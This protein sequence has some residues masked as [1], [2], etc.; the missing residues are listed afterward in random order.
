MV[1]PKIL[2]VQ[3][4][5]AGVFPATRIATPQGWRAAAFLRPGHA[6][7]TVGAGALPLVAVEP[8]PP[9]LWVQTLQAGACGNRAALRLPPGQAILLETDAAIPLA[10]EPF[11]LIPAQALEGWRGIDAAPNAAAPVLLRLARPELIYAGPGLILSMPGPGTIAAATLP[12][13]QARSLV[14]RLVAEDL[15]AELGQAALRGVDGG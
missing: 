12:L 6:V 1:V 2:G 4:L 8:Q 7:L 15:G 13:H 11:A 9:P 14:A 10:G 5:V 3:D